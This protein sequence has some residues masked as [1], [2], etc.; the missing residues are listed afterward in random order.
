M[1]VVVEQLLRTCVLLPMPDDA[2]TAC[3]FM[4]M[5]SSI[6][7]LGDQSVRPWR[8]GREGRRM[9]QARGKKGYT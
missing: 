6:T 7:R 4:Q 8:E 9:N 3:G 1:A 5:R 2:V